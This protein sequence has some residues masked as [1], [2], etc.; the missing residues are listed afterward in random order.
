MTLSESFIDLADH[1]VESLDGAAVSY[2]IKH[3]EV[4]ITAKREDICKVLQ[5]LRDDTECQFKMLV[6][7][8]GA[9]YPDRPERFEVVYNLLSLTQNNRIRVKI[10]VGENELVPTATKVF[11]TAAWFER[12]IWTCMV[13]IL[14][15][16]LT[17]AAS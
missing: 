15:G 10:A 17:C 8:C 12:E 5:F 1:I 11:S 13:F 7:I 6:S 3:D 2:E 16:I 4:A 9:D 14:M